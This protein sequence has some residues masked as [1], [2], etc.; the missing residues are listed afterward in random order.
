[1]SRREELMA[2]TA[3][4]KSIADIPDVEISPEDHVPR[5]GVGS[6]HRRQKFEERIAELEK[7]G[8]EI[9]CVS[10]IDPNPWQP[11]RVFDESELQKLAKS[12]TE[13]GLIQPIAVRRVSNGDTK[14]QLI[15]GERRVR[16]HKMVSKSD[17][18]AVIIDASDEDMA[19]LALAEN[20]DRDDLSAYEVAL[21]IKA[22][23]AGFPN[24]KEIAKALGM[25]RGELYR[26]RAFFELPDFILADLNSHPSLLGSHAAQAIVAVVKKYGDLSVSPLETIW[27]RVKSGDLDQGKIASLIE[28]TVTR[29]E[30]IKTDRDIKK[31]FVGKDQAGSMTR[32]ASGFTIKI[33]AAALTP[34]KETELRGFVERMFGGAA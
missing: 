3:N 8:A 13:V 25:T 26:Y 6:Y 23:E 32:D 27:P 17:I 22:A 19:A 10:D 28:S 20:V 14:F 15:A 2:K 18:K 24:R 33:K 7:A 16:A 4:I 5:S 11:R 21:A 31:L 30:P 1:M 12:I 9:I 29:G 34:E